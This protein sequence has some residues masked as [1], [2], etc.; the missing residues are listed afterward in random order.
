MGIEENENLPGNTQKATLI[1]LIV[2]LVVGL[3]LYLSYYFA[4]VGKKKK[5]SEFS[6]F[7]ISFQK[8]NYT[9]YTIKLNYK[10]YRKLCS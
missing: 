8:W 10:V 5:E 9:N 4:N 1:W 3:I 7:Q 6:V 2:A